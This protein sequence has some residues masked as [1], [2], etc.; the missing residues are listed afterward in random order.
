MWAFLGH[1]PSE[2]FKHFKMLKLSISLLF[3]YF[4]WNWGLGLRASCLLGRP[5]ST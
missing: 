4:W 1:I 3:I 5:S 2:V